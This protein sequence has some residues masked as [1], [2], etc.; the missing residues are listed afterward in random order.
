VY[1]FVDF[2]VSFPAG[3]V[4]LAYAADDVFASCVGFAL[5]SMPT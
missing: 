1:C 5:M 2:L 4:P 3:V